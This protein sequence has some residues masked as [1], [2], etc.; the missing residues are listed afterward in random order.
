MPVLSF[1]AE[2]VS[3]IAFHLR[4]PSDSDIQEAIE[5]G[6]SLSLVCRSWYPI[7]QALRWKDLRIDITSGPSL[8]AH[9]D[10]YPHLPR[11]VTTFKQLRSAGKRSETSDSHS[12]W[13]VDDEGSDVLPKLLGTL[14]NLRALNLQVQSTFEPVLRA[15]AALSDLRIFS[16]FTMRP[17]VWND[18]VDSVFATGFPSLRN[19]MFTSGALLTH[20][21]DVGDHSIA[22]RFKRLR[23]VSLSWF[24]S[25]ANR[26]VHSILSTM[27][28]SA[29]RT[30][31]LG[32]I[33]ANTFPFEML[34][35]CPNL[36]SVRIL[37]YESSLASSFPALLSNL[38]PATSLKSLKY[39]VFP[40][41]SSYPSPLTL[42]A[43]FASFPSNLESLR[44]HQLLLT[45]TSSSQDWLL[46]S[47]E[48]R[49]SLC[50]V[51]GL[52]TT[53]EGVRCIEF[54]KERDAEEK[55]GYRCI[56]DYSSWADHDAEYVDC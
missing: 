24:D 25:D 35:N 16:L 54:W 30:L 12:S 51:Q 14:Q 23:G 41:F 32:G 39:K 13:D 6:Q 36:K 3:K 2:I 20:E 10:L 40:K 38:P 15:A 28:L 34:S 4:A 45:T 33:P 52:T 18:D 43:L 29:L 48:P 8:I 9:F 1:P 49:D 19:F 53:S 47:T 5:A 42:D 37:V 56:L 31:F 50:V 22:H 27:D 55:K 7:G 44:V 11:L 17:L 46:V 26:L 21:A